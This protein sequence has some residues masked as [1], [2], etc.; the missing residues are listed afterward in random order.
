M[1]RANIPLKKGKTY[2]CLSWDGDFFTAGKNYYCPKDEHLMGNFGK[3]CAIYGLG[4]FELVAVKS[5]L[6]NN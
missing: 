6:C 4:M 3:R 5:Q 1:S 2:R